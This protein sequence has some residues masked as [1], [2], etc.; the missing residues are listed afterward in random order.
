MLSRIF[1]RTQISGTQYRKPSLGSCFIGVIL[2]TVLYGVSVYLVFS[3]PSAWNFLIKSSLFIP[4][5]LG[6]IRRVTANDVIT[7][8]APPATDIEFSKPGKYVILSTDLLPA[9]DRVSL[10]SK[11]TGEP[12]EVPYILNG[13]N[14]YWSGVDGRPIFEFYIQQSGTYQFAIEKLPP[15]PVSEYT[16]Y[17]VPDFSTRNRIVLASSCLLHGTV[18]I[19]AISTV[20]YWRNKSRQE[21]EEVEKREKRD[22]FEA[23]MAK[24]KTRRQ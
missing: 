12:I 5:Q 22:K 9:K 21:M 15:G 20:Y 11:E 13:I 3:L 8:T 7:V 24:E 4:D 6:L 2:G 19:L 23:W 16:L 10:R 14:V 17:I 1:K 18:V